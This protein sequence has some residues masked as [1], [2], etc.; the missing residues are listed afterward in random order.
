MCSESAKIENDTPQWAVISLVLFN[1]MINSIFDNVDDRFGKFLFADDGAI[2]RNGWDFN[3]LFSQ[4][5]KGLDQIV[6]W[7]N[8]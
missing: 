7:A 4:T 2:C 1:V 5:Q 3:H 8:N 6:Q